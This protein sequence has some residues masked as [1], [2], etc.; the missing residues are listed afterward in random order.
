MRRTSPA[1]W[2]VWKAARSRVGAEERWAEHALERSRY[3]L[4]NGTILLYLAGYLATFVHLIGDNLVYIGA[5]WQWPAFI[6]AD[7]LLSSVWPLSLLTF[8]YLL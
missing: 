7:L 6:V 4:I 5:W 3:Y 2:G 8:H 1:T